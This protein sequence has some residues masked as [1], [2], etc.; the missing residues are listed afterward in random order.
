LQANRREE[1]P[2]IVHE[3]KKAMYMTGNAQGMAHG[4]HWAVCSRSGDNARISQSSLHGNLVSADDRRTEV[5][6]ALRLGADMR[7]FT[8]DKN[9]IAAPH[10]LGGYSVAQLQIAVGKEERRDP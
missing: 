10:S 2:G 7:I 5:S 1:F 9:S 6:M 8:R 4:C 3:L